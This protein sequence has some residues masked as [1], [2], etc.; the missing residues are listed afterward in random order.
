MLG[1]LLGAC[2]RLQFRSPLSLGSSLWPSEPVETAIPAETS[3]RNNLRLSQA[4][5]P[6]GFSRVLPARKLGE[7]S[8][9]RR[10]SSKGLWDGLA[11]LSTEHARWPSPFLWGCVR[12]T[13]NRLFIVSAREDEPYNFRNGRGYKLHIV[14]FNMQSTETFILC[15]ALSLEMIKRLIITMFHVE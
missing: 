6:S 12:G 11:G 5:V 9:T 3:I 1:L 7:A 2:F 14:L 10:R 15:W 13:Q 8:P 4:R